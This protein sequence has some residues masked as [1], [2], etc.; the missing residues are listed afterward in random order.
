MEKINSGG[1]CLPQ[2]AQPGL[3]NAPFT[4][5]SHQVSLHSHTS[6]QS[7]C[8]PALR[9]SPFSAL[10]KQFVLHMYTRFQCRKI[11]FQMAI[12]LSCTNNP[13]KSRPFEM[14]PCERWLLRISSISPISSPN[15]VYFY[16]KM[17]LPGK[18]RFHFSFHRAQGGGVKRQTKT[19]KMPNKC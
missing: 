14:G 13:H 1:I 5:P 4:P 15:R 10:H 8:I 2:S 7:T 19:P 17:H 11:N 6:I 16:T 12:K 18:R 3:G 9:S